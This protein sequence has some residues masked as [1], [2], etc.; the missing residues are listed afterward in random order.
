MKQIALINKSVVNGRA[1]VYFN[2]DYNEYVVKFY[3][4][5]D[6]YKHADYF[7]DDVEDAIDTAHLQLNK[8]V[9]QDND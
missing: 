1:I 2:S 7:T 3:Q 5:N 8:W 9:E 4:D 6:Y